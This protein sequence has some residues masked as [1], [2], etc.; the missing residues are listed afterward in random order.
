MKTVKVLCSENKGW[1]HKIGAW[2]IKKSEGT[3]FNH[4]AILDEEN[5]IY[6]A[7]FPKSRKLHLK[8]WEKHFVIIKTYEIKM[9][10]E[11]Y[12]HFMYEVS[13]CLNKRYSLFQCFMIWVSNSVGVLEAFI[14]KTVWNGNKALICS[15]LVAWP[16][17]VVLNYRFSN[18][19]DTVG[20]DEIEECLVTVANIN[21]L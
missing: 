19:L 1:L 13:K 6:E 14:E 5:F 20:M 21:Y 8:E 12:D 9:S 3:N 11:K 15:E 18:Y 7:V 10:K 4:V 16:I 17:K 2:A